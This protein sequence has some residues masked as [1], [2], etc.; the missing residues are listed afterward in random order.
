MTTE[1][2]VERSSFGLK[3]ALLEDGRLVEL[4]LF[5]QPAEHPRGEIRLGRVRAID[6]DLNAAFVDCGLDAPAWLGAR[7]ARFLMGAG[8]DVPIGRML[9][10][11]QEVLVQVRH[12]AGD[13]KGA[14]LTADIA[15]LGVYLML[16]PRRRDLSLSARLAR[17]P[18]APEQRARAVALLPDAGVMLRRAAAAA[19]DADLVDELARLREQ[20]RRIEAAARA[21]TPPARLYAEDEPIVRLLLDQLTPDLARIVVGDQATLVRARSWLATWWPAMADR[22]TSTADPFEATGANEQLE[23]ALQATVALA[24]GGSLI[25]QPTAALTAIDV[26]GGGRRA[27][28]SNL[29]AVPEIARQLRLRRLGGTIVV[30]FIDLPARGA[31]ARVLTAL[32]AAVADDPVPVQVFPMARFGLVEISRKRSGPSLAEMLDR[33]CPVCAGRGALP[34]LHWR[35]EQ[36]MRA[37]PERTTRGTAVYVAADLYE[38]LSGTGSAAWQAFGD[39]HG[40]AIALEVDRSLAPGSYRTMES[41]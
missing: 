17:T 35:A 2:V 7:D 31:R 9:D 15:L 3:S 14:R 32:R 36:L 23:E 28:E 20:W 26:N 33:P 6:H 41:P 10:Q 4:A 38:Y 25:I 16:R 24:G 39:R 21:A 8:R 30:D 34:G 12:G 11:G 27:L 37:L 13:G 22:L 18:V 5:D 19:S 40:A 29:A 1:L